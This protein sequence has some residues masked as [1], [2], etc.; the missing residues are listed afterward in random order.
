M[1][2]YKRQPKYEITQT[3]TT[4]IYRQVHSS[5]LSQL[6]AIGSAGLPQSFEGDIAFRGNGRV[7]VSAR[8]A[9]WIGLQKQTGLWQGC[10]SL[11]YP[12]PISQAIF[13]LS[14]YLGFDLNKATVPSP[15]IQE[16]VFIMSHLQYLNDTEYWTFAGIQE[17]LLL[18]E[19]HHLM[20]QVGN[21]RGSF[22]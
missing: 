2:G 1:Q 4:T 20:P 22:D 11:P 6:L 12:F 18:L 9:I 5:P 7:A 3:P 10:H 14:V 16:R 19:Q 17:W 13:Q 8:A 15:V 21:T